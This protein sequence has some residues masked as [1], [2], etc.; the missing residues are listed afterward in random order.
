M[1]DKKDAHEEIVELLDK[2]DEITKKERIHSM[3]LYVSEA[4]TASI[5]KLR[6]RLKDI[7]ALCGEFNANS[8]QMIRK[9]EKFV[10]EKEKE[11]QNGKN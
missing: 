2:I 3:L 11:M 10:F 5:K 8:R 4:N 6:G 9:V 1:E 7:W